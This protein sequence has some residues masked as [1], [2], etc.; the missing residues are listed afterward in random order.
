MRKSDVEVREVVCS[1]TGKP[2]PK[3]PLWMADVKVK[4]V[5]DEARQKHPTPQGLADIEPLRRS[6]ASPVSDLD[7]LKNLDAVVAMDDE[8]E[9]FDEADADEAGE[10]YSEE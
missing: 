3:I 5:S 4:F 7:E 9:G 10:D 1:E 8:E 2:M 6:G